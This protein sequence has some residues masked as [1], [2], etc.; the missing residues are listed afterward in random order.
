MTSC[1]NHKIWNLVNTDLN[2][3]IHYIVLDRD[4]KPGYADCNYYNRALRVVPT[5]CYG[6]WDNWTLKETFY[7]FTSE[8]FNELRYLYDSVLY[9]TN[10]PNVSNDNKLWFLIM[11]LKQV[12]RHVPDPFTLIEVVKNKRD[13]ARKPTTDKPIADNT[14]YTKITALSDRVT[15]LE[16]TIIV[17]KRSLTTVPTLYKPKVLIV[18]T[19]NNVGMSASVGTNTTI[20]NANEDVQINNNIKT[21]ILYLLNPS[22]NFPIQH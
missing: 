12:V 16:S 3:N 19:N 8:V 6:G 17:L 13:K 10:Y 1:V 9:D 5:N 14:F 21:Y 2:A 4:R 7:R 22:P 18:S 11:Y 20:D 15:R